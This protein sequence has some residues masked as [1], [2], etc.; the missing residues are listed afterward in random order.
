[1][2]ETVLRL[3]AYEVWTALEVVDPVAALVQELVGARHTATRLGPWQ[4]G[5]GYVRV[6]HPD[7]TPPCVVPT[8]SLQIS[9]GAALA[10][11]AARCLLPPGGVTVAMLG[12]ADTA[13]PQLSV[14]ARYVPDIS[15]VALCLPGEAPAV[16]PKLVD[17]LELSG[18]GL[19]VVPTLAEAVFGANLVIVTDHGADSHGLDSLRLG[20]LAHGAVLVNA[21]GNDLPDHLVE[22]VDQVFVDD[23]RLLQDHADRAVVA[24]HLS[25]PTGGVSRRITADLGQLLT[26]R[27]AGRLHNDD[28]VLVELLGVDDLNAELAHRICT[29]AA[30]TGLGERIA[31]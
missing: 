29:G 26:R 4:G 14:I 2:S 20:Q 6:D 31:S 7:A 9:L 27:H 15:H 30:S 18:I 23:F 21:T 28:V 25:S 8:H 16:E 19:S 1:M 17:E 13:Q 24:A 3:R 10:A 11:I 5:G 22:P 12:S